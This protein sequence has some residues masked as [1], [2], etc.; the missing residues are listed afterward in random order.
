M[1]YFWLIHPNVQIPWHSLYSTLHFY[2]WIHRALYTSNYVISEVLCVRLEEHFIYQNALTVVNYFELQLSKLPVIPLQLPVC[3]GQFR[4]TLVTWK[5]VDC[6]ILPCE[7][8]ARRFYCVEVDGLFWGVWC[9]TL[10]R[11]SRFCVFDVLWIGAQC[12]HPA[13]GAAARQSD[14]NPRSPGAH[15]E[16]ALYW[17]SSRFPFVPRLR[18]SLIPR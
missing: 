1:S 8:R 4:R 2:D 17:G 18:V 5:A 16:R 12:I 15:P 10:C 13:D 3:C 11:A 14:S 7:T 9:K 6:L